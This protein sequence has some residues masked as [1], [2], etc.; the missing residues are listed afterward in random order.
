MWFDKRQDKVWYM[1]SPFLRNGD[2]EKRR[3]GDKSVKRFLIKKTSR[4]FRF[5]LM[6][7]AASDNPI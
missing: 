6:S 4:D 5:C 2:K 1:T 7:K 3:N